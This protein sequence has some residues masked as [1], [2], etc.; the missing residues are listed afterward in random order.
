MPSTNNAIT[1]R[2][3]RNVCVRVLDT[4]S[5]TNATPAGRS[6]TDSKRLIL[7]TGRQLLPPPARRQW[8]SQEQSRACTP[9]QNPSS[10][11]GF[12]ETDQIL[13]QGFRSVWLETPPDLSASNRRRKPKSSAQPTRHPRRSRDRNPSSS[14]F[15]GPG[16]QRPCRESV[17]CL[18]ARSLQALACRASLARPDQMSSPVLFA[19]VKYIGCHQTWRR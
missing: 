11:L 16:C 15:R 1:V 2:A 5:S 7:I 10:Q 17:R 9:D 4:L 8:P 6:V 19:A 18:D 13:P 14:V 12:F 3:S